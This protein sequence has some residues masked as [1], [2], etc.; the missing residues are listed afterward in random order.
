MTLIDE[1]M[2]HV[3]WE[4]ERDFTIDLPF[5]I[6]WDEMTWYEKEDY[7]WELT[8]INFYKTLKEGIV[9][10]KLT[11]Y[12][13]L[14]AFLQEKY[15]AYLEKSSFFMPTNKMSILRESIR[16]TLS[17]ATVWTIGTNV[18]ED[19]ED[20]IDFILEKEMRGIAKN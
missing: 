7:L 17:P 14:K 11:G 1:L 16:T 20:V 8:R 3:D 2:D 4:I 15:D 10:R 19:L 5:F 18:V 9:S 12:S 6:D 13:E